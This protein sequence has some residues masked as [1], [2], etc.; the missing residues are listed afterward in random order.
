M[1]IWSLALGWLKWEVARTTGEALHVF[2]QVSALAH[3][4]TNV[5]KKE[6]KERKINSSRKSSLILENLGAFQS[7]VVSLETTHHTASHNYVCCWHCWLALFPEKNKKNEDGLQ[8]LPISSSDLLGSLC[9]VTCEQRLMASGSVCSSCE[10]M[11]VTVI[12]GAISSFTHDL[13]SVT[14]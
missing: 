9:E 4:H 6:K 7:W 8:H 11:W 12:L 14:W 10:R 13:L 2:R 3:A 5:R 1:N